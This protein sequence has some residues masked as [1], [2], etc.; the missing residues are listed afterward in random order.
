MKKQLANVTMITRTIKI[1][2][3]LDDKIVERVKSKDYSTKTDFVLHAMR[4]TLI[5]Y[6]NKKKE[7]IKSLQGNPVTDEL[8]NEVYSRVTE[9]FLRGFDEHTGELIQINVRVPDGLDERITFLVKP[10]YGLKRKADFIRASIMCLLMTLTE[11]D[12]IFEDAEKFA[13]RQKQLTEMINKIVIKG[14]SEGKKSDEILKEAFN[15][16]KNT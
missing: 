6:A 2:K 7:L 9:T 3:T 4:E 5:A 10:E 8:V 14:L 11:V 12:D 1:P 16:L 15:Q 13:I